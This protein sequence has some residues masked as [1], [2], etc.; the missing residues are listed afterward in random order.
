MSATWRGGASWI[1]RVEEWRPSELP[2]LYFFDILFCHTG[3][4]LWHLGSLILILALELLVP[5]CGGLF[6]WSGIEPRPPASR[7]RSLSHW[8][9]RQVPPMYC[10]SDCFRVGFYGRRNTSGASFSEYS[11]SGAPCI[12]VATRTAYFLQ[13]SCRS[14]ALPAIGHNS[15]GYN[16]WVKWGKYG[17]T[18]NPGIRI[19]SATRGSCS[20]NVGLSSNRCLS[21]KEKYISIGDTSQPQSSP[22]RGNVA[23]Q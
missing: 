14:K 23:L 12:S 1:R 4:S 15:S 5:A 9:T 19:S 20:E 6:P 8:T 13:G 10:Y 11:R 3:S 16:Q 21:V 22:W 7:V 2:C 18:S 17:I